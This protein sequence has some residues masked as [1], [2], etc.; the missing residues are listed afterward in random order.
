MHSERTRYYLSSAAVNKIYSN[1]MRIKSSDKCIVG[2]LDDDARERRLETFLA[3]DLDSFIQP[4][5]PR[6][7]RS[8]P[9]T[10]CTG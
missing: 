5:T 6:R 2:P 10:Q 4:D 8:L 3:R 9:L 7:R 1:W